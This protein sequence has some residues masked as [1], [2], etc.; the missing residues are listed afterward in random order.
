M[1]QIEV[2]Q[3]NQIGIRRVARIN[4]P[5]DKVETKIGRVQTE[6]ARTVQG[7]D[8]IVTGVMRITT[9][10][11]G[12]TDEASPNPRLARQ[13]VHSITHIRVMVEPTGETGRQ[14]DSTVEEGVH[15][16]E[17]RAEVGAIR[18]TT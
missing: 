8:L 17:L 15:R 4:G 3:M 18:S 6:V 12:E 14:I 11:L 9:G 5:V 10:T 7:D 2:G 13:I 16:I 1:G